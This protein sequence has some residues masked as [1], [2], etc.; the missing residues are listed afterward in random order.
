MCGWS[1]QKNRGE[2][3]CCSARPWRLEGSD[4]RS[5]QALGTLGDLELNGLTLVQRLVAVGLDRGEVHEDIFPGLALNEAISL[6]GIEPL[7]C[8][9]FF[10][11]VSYSVLLN[12]LLLL[13]CLQP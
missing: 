13:D 8:S 2:P 5:L 10:H 12:Y 4:V 3:A 1:K 7:N 9:L 6:A 11:C